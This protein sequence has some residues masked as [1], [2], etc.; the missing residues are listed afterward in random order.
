[1]VTCRLSV[2][3][4][5]GIGHASHHSHSQCATSSFS[6]QAIPSLHFPTGEKK[7]EGKEG[8]TKKTLAALAAGHLLQPSQGFLNIPSRS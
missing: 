3:R 2:I 5:K 4:K 8:K 6:I 1:V 7:S